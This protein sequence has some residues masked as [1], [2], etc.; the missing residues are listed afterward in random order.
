M[1]GLMVS[2]AIIKYYEEVFGEE[3]EMEESDLI[4]I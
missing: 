3:D 1:K 4:S 2:Y